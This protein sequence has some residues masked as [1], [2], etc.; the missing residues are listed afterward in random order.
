MP[1]NARVAMPRSPGPWVTTDS[2]CCG[3]VYE[4]DADK[5]S[6]Q[7]G[8]VR[9]RQANGDQGFRSRKAVLWCMRVEKM[10]RW[11][12]THEGCEAL[13]DE[14]SPVTFM[15]DGAILFTLNVGEANGEQPQP[16]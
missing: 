7:D 12:L 5:V 6:W 3:S 15:N 16:H 9:F 13:Y 4:W 1:V 14:G 11:F 2:C 8:V 10:E